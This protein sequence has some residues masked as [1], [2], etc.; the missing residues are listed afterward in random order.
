M[1][2]HSDQQMKRSISVA[3]QIDE[4]SDRF[5]AVWKAGGD[6]PS[7]EE[8]LKDT[9]A[10]QMPPLLRE[11]IILDVTYRARSGKTP[12]P[13][14]Y[15][16]RFPDH[17]E[18]VYDS[19]Q[20]A[21]QTGVETVGTASV[22]STSKQR[23]SE[24]D[25]EK[26]IPTQIGRYAVRK[27]LGKGAFGTV[28]L[29]YD[30]QL[31]RQVAIKVPH[32]RLCEDSDFVEIFL[33]E[34]RVMATLDHP[35]IV[36]VYDY[37]Q[38]ETGRPYLVSKLVTGTRLCDVISGQPPAD[39][40]ARIVAPIARA[41]HHAHQN[42]LIHRDVKPSNIMIDNAGIPYL[43][44]FGLAFD[45]RKLGAGPT[46]AGTPSY[47]SP[48]QASLQS[49][50]VDGRSDVFSLG[51]VF[52]EM[53]TGARPFT[54]SSQEEVLSRVLGLE[55]RPL[56][57]LSDA[58]PVRYEKVCL[59]ALEKDVKSRYATAADF[60][61]A[62]EKLERKA[63]SP[64]KVFASVALLFVLTFGAILVAKS[65]F[66]KEDAAPLDFDIDLDIRVWRDG[67]EFNLKRAA[68]LFAGDE[69]QLEYTVPKGYKALVCW[70]DGESTLHQLDAV[71][72]DSNETQTTYVWPSPL[73]TNVVGGSSGVE[74]IFICATKP[75]DIGNILADDDEFL[76]ELQRIPD[77]ENDDIVV[78]FDEHKVWLLGEK[79]PGLEEA[80][81][82][83]SKV[84]KFVDAIRRR[85]AKHYLFI[86]GVA[87][88][89]ANR[90]SP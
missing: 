64:V 85:L 50:L 11:L 77:L 41:L 9:P 3:G 60:A 80:D 76:R 27:T 4:I 25:S 19:F 48:E 2:E 89:H 66:L 6:Q 63:R 1:N 43:L 81:I 65:S 22:E 61:K 42:N 56:R 79:G 26:D 88:Q 16:A 21:K 33:K 23:I 58:L 40:T 74:L 18:V 20:L 57:K 35:N 55:P 90:S 32:Q 28:Y 8:H 62:L 37:G 87:F 54:G 86:R 47:M 83:G 67:K 12:I 73:K 13:Q 51:V 36:P 49:N 39:R 53:L 78:A 52:Y 31:D 70:L 34:A 75:S 44:D 69:L 68:P 72:K 17:E 38:S 71:Q 15:L 7:I 14:D 29:G 5:E 46:F 59:Q 82:P 24:F 84:I 10:A 30:D 45:Y